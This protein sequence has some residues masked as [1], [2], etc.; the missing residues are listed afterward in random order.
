VR[1]AAQYG[2][3][4]VVAVL[5]WLFVWPALLGGSMTYV[6]ISGPSMEPTYETGDFV[7]ARE[8]GSYEI[9]DIVVFSTD[10]G[11]V[12]HRIVG[13]DGDAGYVMQGD[14][15]PETDPWNPTDDE[16]LGE[17]VLHVPG[18]GD[19]VMLLRHVVITPPFP[20]LLAAFVFLVIV[21]GDDKKKPGLA[22]DETT[23][24]GDDSEPSDAPESAD[25]TPDAAVVG[26]SVVGASSAL[27]DSTPDAAQHAAAA[28]GRTSDQ[29]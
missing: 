14:N 28:S 20:Y 5:A 11:N 1:R 24:A 3:T 21:L 6:V 25:A 16:V 15:N 10:N 27:A 8:R 23:G 26:A 4:A 18:A 13:G 22:D 19:A 29:P 12:I 17:A 9:G 2:A 7:A